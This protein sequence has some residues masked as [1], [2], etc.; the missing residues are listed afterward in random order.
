MFRS[1][2]LVVRSAQGKEGGIE[3]NQ[4]DLQSLGETL[5]LA[6]GL[7]AQGIPDAAG[8]S[9]TKDLLEGMLEKRSRFLIDVARVLADKS[10]DCL[11]PQKFLRQSMISSDTVY[12]C[13][14][15]PFCRG[16]I[17]EILSA[18]DC[19]KECNRESSDSSTKTGGELV[20]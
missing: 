1:I 20:C 19:Y 14:A 16:R 10:R 15:S 9:A 6:D 12:R 11:S 17:I 2:A 7:E 18:C 4:A 8:L 5:R 3:L 13:M